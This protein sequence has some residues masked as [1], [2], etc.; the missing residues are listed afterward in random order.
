MAELTL[1]RTRTLRPPLDEVY[2]TPS[3]PA[4]GIVFAVLGSL[5][6]WTALLLA[7]HFR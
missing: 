6:V 4:R 2:D 3:S 5:P 7:F 1:N